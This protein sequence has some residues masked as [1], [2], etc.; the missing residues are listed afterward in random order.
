MEATKRAIVNAAD[1][2]MSIIIIGVGQG[3]FSHMKDL[4]ADVRRLS[5]EGKVADRDIVQFVGKF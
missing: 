1:Q 2:A 5:F 4:D 3:D